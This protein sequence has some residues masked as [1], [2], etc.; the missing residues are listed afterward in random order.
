MTEMDDLR[1]R[2]APLKRVPMPDLWP[3][4]EARAGASADLPPAERVRATRPTAAAVGRG[5]F[6]RPAFAWLVVL[7]LLLALVVGV[8]AVGAPRPGP[9]PAV[10]PPIAI[11]GSAEPSTTTPVEPTTAPSDSARPTPS[12]PVPADPAGCPAMPAAPG[13][14]TLTAITMFDYAVDLTAAGCSLWAQSESNNGGIVRIDPTTGRILTQIVPDEVVDSIVASDG[15]IWAVAH[16]SN[17]TGQIQPRL[18]RIDPVTNELSTMRDLPTEGDLAIL[19]DVVWVRDT[20]GGKRWM[21]PLDGHRPTLRVGTS[22]PFLGVAFDTVW[23]QPG[24]TGRL[25]RFDAVGG[26]MAS[27]DVGDASSCAIA[28]T[29]VACASGSGRVL[30]VS[31]ETNTVVW[32]VQLPHWTGDVTSVAA[33]GGSIWVLPAEIG[34]GRLDAPGLVELDAATGAVL[35]DI[36]LPVRQPLD[37][38][39]ELGSLWLAS[40]EQPLARVDLPP[41]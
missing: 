41:R 36:A 20:L 32:S 11:A 5:L 8:L 18:V 23:V 2:L 21:A 6:D 37:L 35:R 29:G 3:T 38:W 16:P 26:T 13:Q 1:D 33:L 19:G 7:V 28:E 4:I 9:L 27:I 22:G 10:V 30:F 17:L 12:D 24:Q 15:A 39:G 40:A 34:P 14:A 31:P 25:E